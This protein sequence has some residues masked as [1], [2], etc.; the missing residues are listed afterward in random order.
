MATVTIMDMIACV[1]RELAMRKRV[2]PRWVLNGK[3]AQSN[4]DIEMERMTA[5]RDTLRKVQLETAD[6]EPGTMP[7]GEV[8][9][10]AKVRADERAK[11][12]GVLLN[13]TGQST[14]YRVVSK[15]QELDKAKSDG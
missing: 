1:E 7:T 15:L 2:Y 3:L 6:K 14:V 4:A 10:P 9:G 8:F 11:I 12:L 5:I 13:L